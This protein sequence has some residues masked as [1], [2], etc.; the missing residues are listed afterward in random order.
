M[1]RYERIKNARVVLLTIW[2]VNGPSV[3]KK[4]DVIT[5]H[6]FGH[7]YRMRELKGLLI[8][9]NIPTVIIKSGR[10]NISRY[11]YLF[12][13]TVLVLLDARDDRFSEIFLNKKNVVLIAVDNRGEGRRQADYIWDALPYYLMRRNELRKCMRR[14]L[15][16]MN[17]CENASLAHAAR[18]VQQSSSYSKKIFEYPPKKRINQKELIRRIYEAGAVKTYFGLTMLVSLYAGKEIILDYPSEYH[19]KLTYYFTKQIEEDPKLLQFLDGKGMNRLQRF[20]LKVFS[21]KN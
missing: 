10:Q 17:L 3:K 8:K 2:G 19:R 11:D 7:L 5:N 16:P 20:I 12:Q 6:G 18:F 15:L 14:S 1:N 13:N 21:K 4:G 9:N